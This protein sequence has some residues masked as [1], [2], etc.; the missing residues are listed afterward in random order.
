MTQAWSCNVSP[1]SEHVA[2]SEDGVPG[3]DAASVAKG[4]TECV[5]P[6]C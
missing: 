5:A 2:A 4:M 1:T 6:P 3:G